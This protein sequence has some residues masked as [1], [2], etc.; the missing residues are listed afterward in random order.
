QRAK[1]SV[2]DGLDRVLTDLQSLY[3]DIVMLQLGRE[4]DIINSEYLDEMRRISEAKSATHT[5][6]V[7]EHL[8]ETRDALGH[9]V[10]P[11]LALESLLVTVITGRK[12]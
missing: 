1:R 11:A 9:N 10:Q 7:L 12:P 4:T 3:R 2:R 5:L 8:S 6:T